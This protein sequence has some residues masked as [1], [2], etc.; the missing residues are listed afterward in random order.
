M[1]YDVADW[2]S[3][4]SEE[5]SLDGDTI[6]NL[7]STE[8][9]ADAARAIAINPTIKRAVAAA[10]ARRLNLPQVYYKLLYLSILHILLVCLFV[11]L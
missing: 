2:L 11:S 5:T 1:A 7:F 3:K 4:L 6:L 8:P 9:D 10:T